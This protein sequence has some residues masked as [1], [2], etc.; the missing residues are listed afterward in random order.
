MID[1]K[2]L[3][4]INL[5]LILNEDFSTGVIRSPLVNNSAATISPGSCLITGGSIDI[6]AFSYDDIVFEIHNNFIPE[7]LGV[8]GIRLLKGGDSR[9]LFEYDDGGAVEITPYI[10]LVKQG[11]VYHGYGSEDGVVWEDAGFVMFPCCEKIGVTLGNTESYQLNSIKLYKKTYIT[12]KSVI[13]D[14]RV[15]VYRNSVLIE[16]KIAA[17]EEINVELPNFPFDGVIKV[18]DINNNLLVDQALS[19]VWGGDEYT[20]S[21][22]VD[23]YNTDSVI[24][25]TYENEYLGNLNQG[26]IEEKYYAKNNGDSSINITI[27]IAE[28]SEYKEWATLGIDGS[29]EFSSSLNV[30]IGAGESIYFW[31]RIMRP[32]YTE[33]LDPID[34]VG[35]I[36]IEVI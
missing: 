29:E 19:D 8:G 5:G 14:Y 22:N 11:D 33:Q 3:K 23:I 4:K 32:V 20:V 30:D 35:R 1:L 27:K 28:Y 15:E 9:E 10:R 34:T 16:S 24:L 21:P 2:V 7:N 6:D 13:P 17:D 36:F 31:L 26:I 12:L 18:Y 25:S